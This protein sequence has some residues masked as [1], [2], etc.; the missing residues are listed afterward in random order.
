MAALGCL[1]GCLGVAESSGKQITFTFHIARHSHHRRRRRC[2]DASRILC[3]A[4]CSTSASLLSPKNTRLP[5][6]P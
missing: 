1:L 2:H 4:V 5:F 3:Y 6:T